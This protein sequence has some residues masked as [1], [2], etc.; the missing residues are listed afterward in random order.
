MLEWDEY[1]DRIV[2]DTFL[3]LFN[4]DPES[5]SFTLPVSKPEVEFELVLTTSDEL[6]PPST[7]RWNAGTELPLEGRTIIVLRR[8]DPE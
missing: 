5:I 2:D 8:I 1:G 7:G 4:G 3:I 6:G